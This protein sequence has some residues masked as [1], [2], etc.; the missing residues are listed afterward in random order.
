MRTINLLLVLLVT[1]TINLYPQIELKGTMGI[2]FLSFPSVQDYINQSDFTQPGR[3][4]GSFNS[5]V[6]FAGEVGAFVSK[7]FEV[8]LEIP[9]QIFSYTENVSF[10]QYELAY[11][12]I[13]PSVIGYYV[14]A[15]NGYNFKFGGGAGP[16]FVSVT[17][18]KKWQG[19]E[20]SFSSVGF[21]GLLRIE[22]NTALAESVFANI[23][24]DL[25]YDA[26]GEPETDSGSKLV[27][28]VKGET[29]NFDTFSLGLRLGISYLIGAAD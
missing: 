26:N 4:L 14:L 8:S 23:G 28:N 12:L 21:G 20:D 1:F 24:I 5:A 29:V 15:G 10:G 22:G 27:N 7:E 19:T 13:L 25:R 16:R 2:N 17:E 9:Y 18:N 11:N 3:E 6:I